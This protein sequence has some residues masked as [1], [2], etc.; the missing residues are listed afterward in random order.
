MTLNLTI[1]QQAH[2]DFTPRITVIGVGGAGCNA[3]NNMIAMGLD[4]VEFLVANTD[5]QALSNSRAGKRVQLGPHLTQ[6]LGAGAKPEIGRAAAEEATEELARHLEG[7]HM[8]FITAGMGGG[9]GTGAAPVVARMARE[10]G[11]LTV[12]V[13]TKP[14]DFEGRK[15]MRLAEG[16][17]EEM[18]Q[19]VDTLIIIPN[20]NLFRLANERTTFQEAFKMADNVLYMGVRGVTDLM[21]N[22]GLVNLDFADIRTVMAEMGK[23][24]MGTGEAEGEDRAVRAAESAIS[25]PLLDDISMRGAK[26][27]L[28]NI[29][30]GHDM[31]LFELDEATNRIRKEV[32]EDA[33]IIFGTSL[34]PALEG[35]VRVSVVAT[36]IDAAARAEAAPVRLVANGGPAEATARTEIPTLRPAA[37]QLAPTLRPAAAGPVV[38]PA[39]V[40]LGP[41][42]TL[43]QAVPVERAP[44]EV[45]EGAPETTGYTATPEPARPAQG[46][47]LRGPARAP[48]MPPTVTAPRR[49]SLFHR[50]TG[51]GDA[52]RRNLTPERPARPEPTLAPPPR[53][54]PRQAED[55]GLDIPTFLRRQGN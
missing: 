14:F 17:I 37:A 42:P 5:A 31:T 52:M 12:G 15:R 22:P 45:S 44:R 4:G 40:R 23:A 10:R 32:D 54:A 55:S 9:T 1:P 6:G 25:N 13:V 48:E 50:M 26:A 47:V 27:L 39:P 11:I 2:T 36:G 49:P 41:Q 35:R 30:G 38:S 53:E 28:I 24:M 18:Q 46:P 7:V 19:V 29:T 34:D 16:G 21:V 8:V 43:R 3:V 20:Q 33:N 51:L